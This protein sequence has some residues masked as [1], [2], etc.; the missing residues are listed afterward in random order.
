MKKNETRSIIND[1][2]AEAKTHVNI[3]ETAFLD[4]SS[5]SDDPELLKIIFRAAHSLK[6][7]AGFFSLGKIVT[8]SHELESIFTKVM[9]GNLYINEEVSDVLLQGV[10]CLKALI[11]NIHDDDEINIGYLVDILRKY[12]GVENS[13]LIDVGFSLSKIPFDFKNQ[14]TEEFLKNAVLYGHKIYYINIVFNKDLGR[15]Y[16]QPKELFDNIL[17]IGGIA[18]AIIKKYSDNDTPRN[19][20]T[21]NDNLI[22]KNSQNMTDKLINVL[23]KYENAVLELLVTTV[24]DIDILSSAIQIDKKNICLLHYDA[25]KSG[26]TEDNSAQVFIKTPRSEENI[27]IRLDISVINGLMDMANEMI[28]IRNQLFSTVSGYTKSIPGLAPV[29]YDISRLTSD[30]QE[31]IMFLRMQ[32]ISVIFA[33]FPRIIR[34]T[35]KSLNKDI[36][37][38]IIRDDVTLDRYLL[39]ALTDPITQIVK[40]SAAHGLESAEKRAVAGKP[41]KGIISLTS[42]MLDDCAVVEVA[43]DGAGIN[44]NAIKQK[45]LELGLSTS[46]ELSLMTEKEIIN[47]IFETGVSTSKQIT[48]ISGRGF[49]MDIVKN[50][51]EKLGGSIEID[52]EAGKGTTVRL[53]MPITLT[54]I[55]ALIITIDSIPYAVSDLNIERIVRISSDAISKRIERVNKSLVLILNGRII[56]VVSMKEIEA[57][58]KGKTTDADEILK[59]SRHDGIVKCLVLNAGV[60]SFALLID[61]AVDTEQILVKHLPIYLQNCPCFSNVTVLGNGKAVTILNTEGIMNYMGLDD[62]Q[63]EAMEKLSTSLRREE[64]EKYIDTKHVVIFNCSGPEY[65]AVEMKDITRIEVISSKDIQEIGSGHFVNI[66]ENTVRIVRPEDYA[67]VV[68]QD[69]T[70]DKLYVLT[71]K[72]GDSLIGLLIKKVLDKVEDIFTLDNEQFYSDF[73]L[74][75]SVYNEKIVIFLNPSAIIQEVK[76]EKENKKIAKKAGIK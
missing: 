43:D 56:P 60:K 39:E 64:E 36:T 17:S 12:S 25:S 7:T 67:P 3:I 71:L 40:N 73:I 23:S 57:K 55:R 30:V 24:L 16:K 21:S 63:K 68:K 1:F 34:D 19:A 6:G 31:K 50:N 14:E 69:Y 20:Q 48:K 8:V 15:Y 47:F 61:D 35:A 37:V 33:K 45:V 54:V 27:S 10:D 28:L 66:A 58:A 38:E 11:D 5:L 53:I 46:E 51:I 44:T 75:T 70:Q 22:I 2:I 26:N 52:S 65:Y 41:I 72:S 32:P 49:G 13:E 4:S 74:G 9:E 76:N 18:E 59:Q 42:Y 62:I 29:L